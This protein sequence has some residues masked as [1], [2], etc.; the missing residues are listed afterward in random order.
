MRSRAV[1]RPKSESVSR[2]SP[3]MANVIMNCRIVLYLQLTLTN[4]TVLCYGQFKQ[5]LIGSSRLLSTFLEDLGCHVVD[6]SF[7]SDPQMIDAFEW[8][9]GF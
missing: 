2:N 7:V 8:P 5:F 3:S 1:S 9:A 4:C 6:G